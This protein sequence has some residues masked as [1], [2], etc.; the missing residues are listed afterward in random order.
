MP[1]SKGLLPVLVTKP[2]N[3]IF[4][5]F[6][7]PSKKSKARVRLNSRRPGVSGEKETQLRPLLCT[8]IAHNTDVANR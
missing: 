3:S 7:L 2:E 1:M 5:T 8:T 6:D 4:L